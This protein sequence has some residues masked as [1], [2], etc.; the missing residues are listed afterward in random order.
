MLGFL[1]VERSDVNEL[2]NEQLPCIKKI[3][4]DEFE[5]MESGAAMF[6]F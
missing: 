1:N 3:N 6:Q 4:K 5:L 2:L